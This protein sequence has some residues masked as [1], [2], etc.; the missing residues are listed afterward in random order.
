MRARFIPVFILAASVSACGTSPK[1]ADD[2]RAMAPS[3]SFVDHEQFVVDRPFHEVARTLRQRSDACLQVTVTTSSSG[4]YGSNPATFKQ[5]Y[6]ATTTAD[7]DRAS[8]VVQEHIEGTNLIKVHEEPAGG[9]FL[10]VADAA[11]AGAHRTKIDLYRP[12]MGNDVLVRAVRGWMTGEIQG[13]P[14][15]TR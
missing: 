2:F 7:G 13:C 9:Y 11:P 3:S 15:L 4:G 5:G 12:T 6:L 14:D 1:T 8:L 10:L